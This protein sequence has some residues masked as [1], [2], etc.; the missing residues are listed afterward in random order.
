MEGSKNLTVHAF[1]HT[2]YGPANLKPLMPP[3]SHNALEIY[4][5]SDGFVDVRINGDVESAVTLHAKQ[6][7]IFRPNLIHSLNSISPDLKVYNLELKKNNL[8]D[9]PLEHLRKSAYVHQFPVAESLLSQWNDILIF[10]DNQNVAHIL[11]KF[12]TSHLDRDKPYYAAEIDI[13]LR[14]LLVEII[15]CSPANIDTSG[16]N[17]HVKKALLF[18][19]TNYMNDIKLFDIARYVGISVPHLHRLFKEALNETVVRR[20]NAI[21]MAKA[22]DII[23]NTN[24]SI[25]EIA[26][27]I[28]FMT[29]QAF[30][31][32]FKKDTGLAP[33]Q[34]RK[35]E[36]HKN[37]RFKLT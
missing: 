3:H 36:T 16:Q 18:I 23:L 34:Y 24:L 30:H 11:K 27:N 32:A 17:I 12:K 2:E 31:T 26:R 33:L 1:H 19:E 10:S 25:A 8:L 22:K 5:V 15:Q 37:I 4:Y 21:R 20:L 9:D 28:G 6:F 13:N 35:Q 14:R 29:P 7:I